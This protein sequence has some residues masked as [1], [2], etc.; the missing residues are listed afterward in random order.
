MADDLLFLESLLVSTS[1][2]AAQPNK[3]IRAGEQE[4]RAG[5]GSGRATT[6]STVRTTT[7]MYC[8][9]TRQCVP[10]SWLLL[11]TVVLGKTGK[12]RL[13]QAARSGGVLVLERASVESLLLHKSLTRSRQL[14]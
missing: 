14:K 11:V 9:G 7:T 3:E 4:W 5:V 10:L 1:K 2:N 8:S 13:N 6:T 12:R